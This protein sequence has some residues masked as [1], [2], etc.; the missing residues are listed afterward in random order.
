M[1]QS[2]ALLEKRKAEIEDLMVRH[3]EKLKMLIE[4]YKKI[5]ETINE[6]TEPT[7]PLQE[8]MD[9]EKQQKLK[10][11]LQMN[12]KSDQEKVD[13]EVE[14]NTQIRI[15]DVKVPM[16][17][18]KKRLI[19]RQ[20][21]PIDQI[22][23]VREDTENDWVSVGV[24][25]HISRQFENKLG[26]KVT[27]YECTDLKDGYFRLFTVD[28]EA[29]CESGSVVA[30]LNCEIVKPVEQN[31]TIGLLLPNPKLL[32]RLGDSLD[33]GICPGYNEKC[34][35]VINKNKN[36]YCRKHR[37]KIVQ[38]KRNARQEFATGNS[39]LREGKPEEQRKKS[40]VRDISNHATY[41]IG[42]ETIVAEGVRVKLLS[43]LKPTVQSAD[44]KEI[45]YI[46]NSNVPAAKNIRMMFGI[47][48]KDVDAP[49]VQVFGP[50]LLKKMGGNPFLKDEL[51]LTPTK[52]SP[53]GRDRTTS[54]TPSTPTRTPKKSGQQMQKRSNDSDDDLELEILAPFKTQ[55]KPKQDSSDV[56]LEIE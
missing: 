20:Y 14:P 53:E 23:S 8:L 37:E 38:E 29:D 30:L 33:L 47:E 16:D 19:G 39:S 54:G 2:L 12:V 18:F 51:Q 21:V 22:L 52:G 48:E 31:G 24:V 32:M 45:Q 25:Y 49:N 10:P 35:R 3:K 6:L 28:F 27:C 41:R 43:P 50:S 17:T 9:K 46:I 7:N 44:P 5:K 40:T 11:R 4:E 1:T 26:Q 55:K 42:S 34:Y 56:E 13:F 15:R 36:L